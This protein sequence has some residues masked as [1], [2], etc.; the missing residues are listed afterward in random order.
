V[1]AVLVTESMWNTEQREPIVRLAARHRVP[2]LY[3]RREFVDAGGLASYGPSY[4]EFFRRAAF[5][6]DRILRGTK[7]ADLPIEQPTK[8]ELVINLRTAR[9]LGLTIPSSLQARADAIVE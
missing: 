1:D 4:V 2:A 9:A 3:G 8:I 5:Y 7:P 6:V